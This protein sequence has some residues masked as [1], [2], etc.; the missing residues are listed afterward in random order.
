MKTFTLIGGTR[1]R[2]KYGIPKGKTYIQIPMDIPDYTFYDL[3]L[4][5][6]DSIK[7]ETY[8]CKILRIGEFTIND[9]FILEGIDLTLFFRNIILD[10]LR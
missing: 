5:T 10:Y 7:V 3:N 6:P 4:L 8:H 1:H 2:Q 9:I